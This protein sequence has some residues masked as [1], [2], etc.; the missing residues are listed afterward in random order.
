VDPH[1]RDRI[2]PPLRRWAQPGDINAFFGLMLDNMSDLVI[3]AESS[4]W[5][6]ES[7]RTSCSE[8]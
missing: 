6:S 5:R 2:I 4:R 8:E 3:M 7:R 1:T